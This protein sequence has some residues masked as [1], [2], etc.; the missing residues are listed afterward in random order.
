MKEILVQFRTKLKRYVVQPRLELRRSWYQSS[1]FRAKRSLQRELRSRYLAGP[2]HRFD[3]QLPTV[4]LARIIGNDLYPRHAEGQALINLKTVLAEEPD[5]PGWHKVFVLNRWLDPEAVDEAVDCVEASGHRAVVLPFEEDVYKHISCDPSFFGGH[6]YFQ[7]P[8]FAAKSVNQR[9][10]ERLWAC[11]PKVQYLMNVN[12]ARN[13]ALD[14]GRAQTDWTFVLDGSCFITHEAHRRL[15]QDL[16]RAPHTPYLVLPMRR[17][18]ANSDLEAVNVEPNRDEEPQLAFRF[19]T[20][21]AF[22]ALFPYG[23]RD[24]TALLDR[25]GIPGFWNL[26]GD[27]PWLPAPS[28]KARERHCY[29]YGSASVLRLTSGVAAGSLEAPAAQGQ[30]YRSRAE[31]IFLT[32]AAIDE[33]CGAIDLREALVLMGLE[34]PMQQPGG[35]CP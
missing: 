33:R 13:V 2:V 32:L 26:W 24:K 10:R 31:A 4:T 21:E 15:G 34:Q 22:D 8:Q 28:R 30:R 25:L 11:A 18:T 29:K 27:M 16:V 5:F 20:L 19:D 3:A 23:M 35:Q 14:L 12:G 1:L 17:L 9:N 7:S 6:G